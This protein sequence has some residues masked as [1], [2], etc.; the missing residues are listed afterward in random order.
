MKLT[1]FWRLFSVPKLVILEEPVA[2][3]KRP[4]VKKATTRVDKKPTAKKTVA[5]K[6]VKKAK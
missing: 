3:K 5:K 6:T 4:T 2:V 1:W